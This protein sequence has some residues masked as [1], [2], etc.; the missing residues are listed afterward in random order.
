MKFRLIGFTF[1]TALN[2]YVTYQ[3]WNVLCISNSFF[4]SE[5]FVISDRSGEQRPSDAPN[6]IAELITKEILR[7]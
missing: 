4:E 5:G 6:L 1:L 7:T 3:L 2:G